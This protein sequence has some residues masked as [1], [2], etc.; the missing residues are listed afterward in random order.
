MRFEYFENEWAEKP[1][2][3]E[4]AKEVTC[5]VWEREYKGSG[6]AAGWG[7]APGSSDFDITR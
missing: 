7:A 3:V 2:W 4:K 1:E 5:R 6:N